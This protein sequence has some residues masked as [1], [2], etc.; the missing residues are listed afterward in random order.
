[1]PLQGRSVGSETGQVK[2]LRYIDKAVA[3]VEGWLIVIFLSL[4]VASTFVQIVLRNLYTHAQIQ[5]ANYILGQVDWAE[6][7]A[8]LLVL[9]ITFLG[10]SLLTGDQKHIKIDLMSAL[11]PRRWLPFREVLLS[12]ACLVVCALLL[13]ASVDYVRVEMAF[14]GSLFLN[15][16]TWVGQLILP[17]GFSLLLFRFFVKGLEQMMDMLRSKK[18]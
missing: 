15:L 16:P 9:W 14:G 4:M 13:K 18:T 2:I 11:L 7:F 3:R 5:W 8:R 6:P 1:L 17:A 10:A 12:V